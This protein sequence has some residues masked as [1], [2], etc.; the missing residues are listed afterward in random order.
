MAVT[1]IAYPYGHYDRRVRQM[2]AAAGYSGACT[3]DSWAAMAD[4]H[5]LELPRTTVFDDT[6]VRAWLPGWQPATARPAGRRCERA[7]P[8]ESLP[9]MLLR[10]SLRRRTGAR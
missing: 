2:V 8:P 6:D 7:G 10:G 9:G 1:S 3:M 4:D 5:P